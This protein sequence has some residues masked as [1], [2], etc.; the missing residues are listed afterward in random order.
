MA[1]EKNKSTK[2]E[3]TMLVSFKL[4]HDLH[5]KLSA[6]ADKQTDESGLKLSPSLAARRLMLEGLKRLDPKK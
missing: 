1:K 2:G 3:Q 6:Y 5:E 4:S